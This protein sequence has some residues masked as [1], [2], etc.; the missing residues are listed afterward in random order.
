MDNRVPRG[1]QHG[2]V[3][4]RKVLDLSVAAQ[5]QHCRDGEVAGSATLGRVRD[6]LAF[7]LEKPAGPLRQNSS[8]ILRGDHPIGSI[9][10]TDFQGPEQRG[11]GQTRRRFNMSEP[12]TST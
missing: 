9:P 10:E 8:H 2:L 1:R 12:T 7:E 11:E 4:P 3:A 5:E 6:A